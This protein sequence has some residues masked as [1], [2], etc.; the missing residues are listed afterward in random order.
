M[1]LLAPKGTIS[2][3]V[4]A[5]LAIYAL[6]YIGWRRYHSS[7]QEQLDLIARDPSCQHDWNMLTDSLVCKPDMQD[8]WLDTLGVVYGAVLH[9]ALFTAVITALVVVVKEPRPCDI[10]DCRCANHARRMTINA[11]AQMAILFFTFALV[12]LAVAAVVIPS[13][14]SPMR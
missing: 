5:T 12:A 10:V 7:Y 1:K 11:T 9:M 4:I 3:A 2:R 14:V 13:W 8:V 6:T